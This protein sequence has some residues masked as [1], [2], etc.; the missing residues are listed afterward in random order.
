M[1]QEEFDADTF[2]GTV[3]TTTNEIL[4]VDVSRAEDVF[5]QVDSGT[6]DGAPASYDLTARSNH[7]E[8]SDYMQFEQVTGSTSQK[9]EFNTS[10]NKMQFE[11][12]NQSGAD[13]TYRIVVKSYRTMD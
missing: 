7:T 9:H 2:N 3:T 10:G 5:V 12:N 11:F 1:T 6:T 4:E 13:A 8:V